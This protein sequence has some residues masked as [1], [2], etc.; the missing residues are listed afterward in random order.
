MAAGLGL[1]HC[2][3]MDIATSLEAHLKR[4]DIN[5]PLP[6]CIFF[7]YFYNFSQTVLYAHEKHKSLSYLHVYLIIVYSSS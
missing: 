3:G 7:I 2:R 5:F 1:E 4:V 6:S